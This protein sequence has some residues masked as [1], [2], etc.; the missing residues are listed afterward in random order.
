MKEKLNLKVAGAII[1]F[2]VGV[3]IMLLT[4]D[5]QTTVRFMQV[6]YNIGLS[7]VVAGVVGLFAELAFGSY[8]STNKNELRGGMM[9]VAEIRNG[10][11]GYHN[12]LNQKSVKEVQFSGRSVLHNMERDFQEHF[13]NG[14]ADIFI[15]QMQKG[16]NIK[17]LFLDP[18][19]NMINQIS[20]SEGRATP[21]AL[22]LDLEKSLIIIEELA[23][24]LDEIKPI[25]SIDIKVVSEIN[26]Y[27]YHYVDYRS[28]ETSEMLVGFYFADQLGFRSSL[29]SV[30]DKKIKS[31]FKQ[32]FGLLYGKA[33]ELL[34]YTKGR[35]VEFK[36]NC[37][38][39]RMEIIR[40]NTK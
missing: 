38:T 11:G 5:L 26:Q 29:F 35:P 17:V 33:T 13:R 22:Y 14:V 28:D 7:L 27:A 18:A 6:V 9:E 20:T 19:W 24:K 4:S 32:H 12:W 25:G 37:Y 23:K 39:E 30:D 10:Y 2:L 16:V 3:I 1:M 40:N 15:Q 34:H 21:K 36:R 8:W 31:S